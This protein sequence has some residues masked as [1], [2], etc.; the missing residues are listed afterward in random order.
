MASERQPQLRR[1]LYIETD[2]A[3]LGIGLHKMRF[4]GR[5]WGLNV[6][7]I[8]TRNRLIRLVRG[9]GR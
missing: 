7:N 6:L 2:R 9:L 5:V 1:N 8:G 3:M 4:G